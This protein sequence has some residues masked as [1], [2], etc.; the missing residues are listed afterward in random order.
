MPLEHRLRIGAEGYEPLEV[1][2]PELQR[3]R[4]PEELALEMQPASG[5]EEEST[6]RSGSPIRLSGRVLGAVSSGAALRGRVLAMVQCRGPF[7][8][9]ANM[10]LERGCPVPPAAIPVGGAR[11]D[12][13]AADVVVGGPGRLRLG[14]LGLMH[15][16]GS[17]EFRRCSPGA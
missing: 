7:A 8:N 16:L 1:R 15:E 9:A 10:R 6:E 4:S 3:E 12:E 2:L 13:D 11:L 14:R 17:P 5:T